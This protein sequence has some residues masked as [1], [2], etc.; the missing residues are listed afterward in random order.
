MRQIRS[1]QNWKSD[2]PYSSGVLA[3]GLA[4]LAGHVPVD[5]T[6][7]TAG[8]DARE[9][10]AAVLANLDRTLAAGGMCRD[11][12]V[13]TVVYLMDMADIDALDDAYREF[14][15]PSGPY[16]SRTTVQISSLGRSEFL[17]EVSA[18]AIAPA[19]ADAGTDTVADV[20]DVAAEP[21]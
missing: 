3:G 10:S 12:I 13:S 14:F 5:A 4:F 17:V 19:V 18:I 7:Q 16:P 20:A 9:Q 8:R 21:A 15:G 1:Q 6:G 2:R 11:D